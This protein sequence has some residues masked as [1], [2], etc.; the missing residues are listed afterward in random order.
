LASPA[1]DSQFD[2]LQS[3]PASSETSA[4]DLASTRQPAFHSESP[5]RPTHRPVFDEDLEPSPRTPLQP[6]DFEE[7]SEV[8][9]THEV[10]ETLEVEEKAEQQRVPFKK[11]SQDGFN[12]D[13]LRLIKKR[14]Q[15]HQQHAVSSVALPP[16]HPPRFQEQHRRADTE[17]PLDVKPAERRLPASRVEGQPTERRPQPMER[18]LPAPVEAQP[19]QAVI[20]LPIAPPLRRQDAPRKV[21]TECLRMS[22]CTCSA[23][24]VGPDNAADD[25]PA[26]EMVA[27]VSCSRKF[28]AKSLAVHE[29][30]CAKVFTVKSPPA[31][32]AKSTTKPTKPAPSSNK[33]RRQ[34]E[35]L[36]KA[37]Q[38]GRGDPVSATVVAE[39]KV[40]TASEQDD[41]LIGCP[42]CERRF[43]EKAAERHIPRCLDIRSKPKTLRRGEG[44]GRTPSKPP[45]SAPP[46]VKQTPRT[47]LAERSAATSTCPHCRRT[48]SSKVLD[49]HLETCLPP[50]SSVKRSSTAAGG[51]RKP[52]VVAWNR[53]PASPGSQSSW[54][55]Y[56]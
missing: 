14:M 20:E 3:S 22:G 44:G 31:T 50:P 17:R 37:M 55:E 8:E 54:D 9:E 16:V 13:H 2:S 47:S 18:R 21:A 51:A 23:C 38:S 56:E 34:S 33:W 29:R 36:R 27:C 1:M 10:E 11:V 41:G 46:P 53:P 26:E 32:A 7:N 25:L 48:F 43:N 19:R 15:Q 39:D 45:P 52:A 28:A 40:E 42:H 35:E 30:V 6:P 12:K 49:R 24:S 5:P 4:Q